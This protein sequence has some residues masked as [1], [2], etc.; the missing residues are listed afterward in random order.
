MKIP[1]EWPTEEMIEAGRMVFPGGR[2]VSPEYIRSIFANMLAAAPTPPTEPVTF[3]W[4][5]TIREYL[6]KNVPDEKCGDEWTKGHEECKRRILR[7][8]QQPINEN[9]SMNAPEVEPVVSR[10]KL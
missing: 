2:M 5:T 7:M 1:K 3:V 6:E 8:L 9:F 10:V 4:T